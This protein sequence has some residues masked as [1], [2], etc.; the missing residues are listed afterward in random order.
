[1]KG[2]LRVESAKLPRAA[3]R[4]SDIGTPLLPIASMDRRQGAVRFHPTSG[5]NLMKYSAILVG[6]SAL[7]SALSACGD[8]PAKVDQRAQLTT[9]GEPDCV[10]VNVAIVD[11]KIQAP[12]YTYTYKNHELIVWTI[13]TPGPYTFPDNGIVFLTNG[14]FIC[15]PHQGGGKTFTCKKNG[16]LLD[17]YKY[18]VNVNAGSNPLPPLPLKPLDPWIY[19]L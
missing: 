16:H 7:A 19:N 2:P 15:H 17:H 6:V 8:M 1:M 5:R 9:C 10:A 4:H 3:G 13:I 14:V 11:M 12:D 18:T